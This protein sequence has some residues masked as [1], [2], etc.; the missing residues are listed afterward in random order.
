MWSVRVPWKQAEHDGGGREECDGASTY[1]RSHASPLR[2]SARRTTH[3]AN[4]TM[5]F[6]LTVLALLAA[7]TML[8]HGRALPW[9]P[10]PGLGR[11]L[12]FTKDGTFQISIFEDLHYGESKSEYAQSFTAGL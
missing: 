4:K 11:P 3:S 6:V 7:V 12:R 10:S 1:N 5:T 8:S 9:K 2:P